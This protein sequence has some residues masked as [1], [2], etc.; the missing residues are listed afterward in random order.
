MH[1]QQLLLSYRAIEALAPHLTTRDEGIRKREKRNRLDVIRKGKIQLTSMQPEGIRWW[2]HLA[3]PPVIVIVISV[4]A[5]LRRLVSASCHG[6]GRIR[7]YLDLHGLSARMASAVMR[8]CLELQLGLG[9]KL[10]L[11]A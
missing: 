10:G 11:L 9:L 2:L 7:R 3:P 6:Q 1:I 8:Y 5:A 4:V